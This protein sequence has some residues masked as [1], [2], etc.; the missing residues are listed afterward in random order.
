MWGNTKLIHFMSCR[1]L[2]HRPYPYAVVVFF[3]MC[4]P[5]VN[6]HVSEEYIYLLEKKKPKHTG[7]LAFYWKAMVIST[8]VTSHHTI[9]QQECWNYEH[10]WRV[11]DVLP[12]LLQHM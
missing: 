1:S 7:N 4:A 10:F 6:I 11:S 2:F 9:E 5:R 12:A 8:T 3:S